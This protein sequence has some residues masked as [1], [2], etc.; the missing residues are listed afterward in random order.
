MDTQPAYFSKFLK[1]SDNLWQRFLYTIP[2]REIG[3]AMSGDVDM[4]CSLNRMYIPT[5]KGQKLFLKIEITPTTSIAAEPLPV[6]VC[7]LIDRSGSMAGKKLDNAKKGAIKLINQLESRDYAGIVTFESKIDVVVPGQHVTDTNI[8]ESRIRGI[9]LGGTTEM[10]KGLRTAFSELRRPLQT[11][12][13]TGKEPV[14]RIV[15]LSDGQPTDSRSESEY[16]TLAREMRKMGISITALGIGKD[17]NEDLLS[18]IAE[19][20]GGMWRHIKSPD[21]IPQMFSGELISMKTVVFSRPELVLNLSEG[22]ELADIYKSEPDVHRIS[23]V[24]QANNEYR[25]PISDIRAGE[26]QTIV[27]RIGVPPR[28][29]GACR[30]AKVDVISGPFAK[31]EH[32]VVNFTSDELLWGSEA[33]SYSRT[34]FAVTE[35]QIKAKEGISGDKTAL[36]QAEAQLKT[37]IRDPEATRIKDIADRTVVLRE[38]LDKTTVMNEEEKKKAKS[39]LTIVKR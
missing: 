21:E 15:L 11:F 24:K 3:D 39:D 23:N 7:L 14:R 4:T 8:F 34:L 27:A 1:F 31:T 16:R 33:D 12:F 19:D 5:G 36:K 32:V 13:S 18:A 30:V 9:S 29:E 22:V 38:V 10:Y 25:I 17:Y 6:N 20:S 35:T 2:I 28:P 26:S 37:I